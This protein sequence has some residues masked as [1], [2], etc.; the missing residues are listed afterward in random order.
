M[1]GYSRTQSENQ[2]VTGTGTTII[3][4]IP[5][6]SGNSAWFEYYIVNTSTNAARAGQVIAVW[7]G[8]SAAFTDVSTTDLNGDTTGLEFTVSVSGGDVRL[9]AVHSGSF[10]VKVNT[11]VVF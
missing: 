7:D 8:S 10:T 5:V 6:S 2:G 4:S 3:E 11:R 9:V 1:Y